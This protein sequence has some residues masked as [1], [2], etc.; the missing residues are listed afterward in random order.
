MRNA[1][2]AAKP[3]AIPE[4]AAMSARLQTKAGEVKLRISTGRGISSLWA[5]NFP[6]LA[7]L[8]ISRLGD[9]GLHSWAVG[10]G[11]YAARVRP[12]AG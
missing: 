12:V 10:R 5:L 6:H 4:L 8:V 11:A 1:A 3:V 9:R 2:S 7:G